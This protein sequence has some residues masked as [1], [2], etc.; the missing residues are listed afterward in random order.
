[1][2]RIEYRPF[3]WI[4]ANQDKLLIIQKGKLENTAD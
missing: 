3:S 2:M 4:T 1:M